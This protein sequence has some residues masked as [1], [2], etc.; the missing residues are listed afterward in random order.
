M[1]TTNKKSTSKKILIFDTHPIQYRSPVFKK[2]SKL[3]KDFL[4]VFFND[5]FDFG[6]WWFHERPKIKT[7]NFFLPLKEG[8]PNITINTEKLGI[9]K[10]FFEIKKIIT[11]EKPSSILIYGYYLPEHWI[12]R[13]LSYK[14]KIPL[15]FIG[16]TFDTSGNFFKRFIKLKIKKFFFSKIQG[17]ISI[18]EKN[19][20]HYLN[21]GILE[22][23][24]VKAKYCVDNSLFSLTK[25]ESEELRNQIRKM[26]SIREKA[27]VI[28]FVGR[29][30]DRKRPFDIL[31][32][33]NR[34]SKYDVY[35]IIVGDGPLSFKLKKMSNEKS[36]ITGFKNQKE[37]KEFYHMSDILI[38][39][40]EYETW[41]LVVNEAF[42]AGIPAIVTEKCGV[43]NELVVEGKTGFIYKVGD[44]DDAAKKIESLILNRELYSTLSKNAKNLVENN[45]S[46]DAFAHTIIDAMKN[47]YL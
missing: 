8:F 12:I 9:I 33:Q 14:Q 23:R 5:K 38:L 26:L 15:F 18:G 22:K 25:K 44:I 36:I 2:I 27:F 29:L 30:F 24:I 32:I 43:A 20:S 34:L 11:N 35:S 6:K 39:P 21:L 28:L 3:Y 45:Y 1:E 10:T 47:K 7:E 46:I 17:I 41:G 16:E 37:L 31:A 42:S 40:S 13:Y 4:V 19:Y